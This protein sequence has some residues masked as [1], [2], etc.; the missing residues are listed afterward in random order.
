[1][2]VCVCVC[3]LL[4][5]P[6]LFLCLS[7]A[8]FWHPANGIFL[9]WITVRQRPCRTNQGTLCY[10]TLRAHVDVSELPSTRGVLAS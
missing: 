8:L 9:L 6:P 10:V 4:S 1:V 5:L 7:A 2:C 3:V